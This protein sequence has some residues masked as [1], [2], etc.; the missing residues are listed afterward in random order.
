MNKNRYLSL[1]ALAEK[2]AV[3]RRKHRKVIEVWLNKSVV[4]PDCGCRL[5]W[6]WIWGTGDWVFPLDVA[7]APYPKRCCTVHPIDHF[8]LEEFQRVLFDLLQQ[9]RIR[10]HNEIGDREL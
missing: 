5:R 6:E 7:V 4:Q 2:I 3:E 1:P 8:D 10:T 9:F